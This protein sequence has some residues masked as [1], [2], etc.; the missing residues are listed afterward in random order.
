MN[1]RLNIYG[2]TLLLVFLMNAQCLQST[3]ADKNPKTTPNLS[4]YE[5]LENYLHSLSDTI[6]AQ[7]YDAIIFISD[8]DGSCISC[9]KSFSDFIC[10]NMLNQNRMLIILNAKGE[11]FN[12]N[13]YFS[14]TIKNV[15]TD[16]SNDFFHL[17]IATSASSVILL[18]EN[19]IKEIYP[20]NNETLESQ[21][22]LLVKMK[23]R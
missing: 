16:Y 23:F 21:I 9:M 19:T 20:V 8:K 3:R 12:T 6:S 14:D 5:R 1:K 15:V 22:L 2:F 13:H 11:R 17:K 18:K 10:Q 7:N 4:P